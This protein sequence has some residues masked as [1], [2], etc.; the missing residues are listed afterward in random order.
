M[1]GR[2]LSVPVDSCLGV[3]VVS[4]LF[5]SGLLLETA[6]SN[7][8][9]KIG[10]MAGK[11]F[12]NMSA[13]MGLAFQGARIGSPVVALAI[14][15]LG[16]FLVSAP[17]VKIVVDNSATK[18]ADK[19]ASLVSKVIGAVSVYGFTAPVLGT[20]A[21]IAITTAISVISIANLMN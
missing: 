18:T 16:I 20:P 21:G 5:C 14:A 7:I 10:G 3:A 12:Q 1:V 19:I 13:F 15:G 2:S 17:V 8:D 4:T 6:L 9:K 11:V